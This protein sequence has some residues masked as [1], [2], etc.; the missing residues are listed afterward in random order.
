MYK[1]MCVS[2]GI[3]IKVTVGI[4]CS[5]DWGYRTGYSTW[6]GNTDFAAFPE[7]NHQRSSLVRTQ[8][9]IKVKTKKKKRMKSNHNYYND[10]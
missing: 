8:S 2:K 4:C 9:N 6:G 1:Y 5:K 3:K 7:T 10:W